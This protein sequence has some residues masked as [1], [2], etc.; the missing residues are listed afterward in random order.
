MFY[1][2]SS[3]VYNVEPTIRSPVH[4]RYRQKPFTISVFFVLLECNPVLLSTKSIIVV[5]VLFLGDEWNNLVVSDLPRDARHYTL[6][7]STAIINCIQHGQ[8]EI[9][10]AT[11]L[12]C[13]TTIKDNERTTGNFDTILVDFDL[14]ST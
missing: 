8:R 14:L 9:D 6:L 13:L 11:A 10:L 5:Y 1:M 12:A 7:T 3:T 2:L 4:F